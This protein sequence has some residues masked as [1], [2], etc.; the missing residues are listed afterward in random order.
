MLLWK[1][2]GNF[3]GKNGDMLENIALPWANLDEIGRV[4]NAPPHRV[5]DWATE[6]ACDMLGYMLMQASLRGEDARASSL[7]LESQLLCMWDH[8]AVR[9]FMVLWHHIMDWMARA[10]MAVSDAHPPPELR[11][12]VLD[13][14]LSALAADLRQGLE[15]LAGHA[16]G[17]SLGGAARSGT[18][19]A[20]VSD[21]AAN[22]LIGQPYPAH[23]WNGMWKEDPFHTLL[24]LG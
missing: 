24:K 23:R 7:S 9:L 10:D 12:L 22:R 2:G 3:V 20:A 4:C 13:F 1:T 8:A 17:S 21:C 18:W 6:L 5:K 14:D 16:H 19:R 11:L 15:R